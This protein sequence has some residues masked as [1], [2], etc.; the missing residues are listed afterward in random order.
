MNHLDPSVL[1][2]TFLASKRFLI[3]KCRPLPLFR[4][5]F[6]F[7]FFF[8]PKTNAISQFSTL[9]SN[10]PLANTTQQTLAPNDPYNRIYTET[11]LHNF[12]TF[13]LFISFLVFFFPVTFLSL[14]SYISPIFHLICLIII[15]WCL[16]LYIYSWIW[17]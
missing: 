3:A 10:S 7:L 16:I 4:N 17:L 5:L 12:A 8:S 1:C 9:N 15:F 2:N 13:C 14:N 11:I 6:S